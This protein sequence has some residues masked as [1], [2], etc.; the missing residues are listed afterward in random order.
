[1]EILQKDRLTYR[2]SEIMQAERKIIIQVGSQVGSQV[3]RQVGRQVQ[4]DNV[5]RKKD[6]QTSCKEEKTTY[7]MTEKPSRL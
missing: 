7:E 6:G 4:R 5:P 2:Y 1:M 3:G